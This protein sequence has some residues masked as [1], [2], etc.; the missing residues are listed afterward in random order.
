MGEAQGHKAKPNQERRQ[1][2]ERL[3][4]EIT[5][6]HSKR[7]RQKRAG[8]GPPDAR[9]TP[10]HHRKRERRGRKRKTYQNERTI[11][12]T[13]LTDTHTDP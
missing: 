11:L 6:K 13:S 5:D 1:E 3:V 2:R 10:A 9:A 8:V 7:K 4:S 12:R